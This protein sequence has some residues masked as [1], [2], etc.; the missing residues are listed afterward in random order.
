[1]LKYTGGGKKLSLNGVPARDLSKEEVIKYGGESVLLESGLYEKVSKK[2]TQNKART[3][4][5]EDK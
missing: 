1:M 2:T 4:A 3:P 5:K